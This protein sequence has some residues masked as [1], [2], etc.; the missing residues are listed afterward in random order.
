MDYVFKRTERIFL[1]YQFLFNADKYTAFEEKI[2]K[3]ESF[4]LVR[5]KP[6]SS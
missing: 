3:F 2:L 4:L 1:N 6:K 5:T